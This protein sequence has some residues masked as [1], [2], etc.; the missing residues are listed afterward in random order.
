MIYILTSL[1]LY[2]KCDA[3]SLSDNDLY[4]SDAEK[5]PRDT[6]RLRSITVD[7]RSAEGDTVEEGFNEAGDGC[8]ET[9]SEDNNPK[10]IR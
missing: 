6:V 10:A 9:E 1:Q 3:V 2:K 5:L 8:I 4:A 7:A